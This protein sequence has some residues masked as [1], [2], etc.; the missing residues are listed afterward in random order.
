MSLVTYLSRSVV[1]KLTEDSPNQQMSTHLCNIG[2]AF[3]VFCIIAVKPAFR[4]V[5]SCDS[6]VDFYC[7]LHNIKLA[8]SNNWDLNT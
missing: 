7:E 8:H 6:G 3:T 1:D 4:A 5:L 2:L